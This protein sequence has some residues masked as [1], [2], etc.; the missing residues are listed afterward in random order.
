[1]KIVLIHPAFFDND[2]F[3][4]RYQDYV[5]WIR[6]GN[7]YVAPFEPPLG[8][9]YI[10]AYVKQQG[11]DVTLLDMQA[12]M[13]DSE[14][15]ASYFLEQRPDIVGITAMTPTL[16]EALRVAKTAHDL[17]PNVK[18]VLGGVHPTL[19]PVSVLKSPYVDFAVRGEG[20]YALCRLIDALSGKNV[21]FEDID[22]LCY[23][24][25]G[26]PHI[27]SKALPIPDLDALPGADYDSFP[28]ERYIEHNSLLR[29]IRGISMIVSRGCPYSC[30]FCAVHQTMSRLYRVK[31]APGVVDEVIDLRDRYGLEGVWFKD[32]IFNLKASWT[33][34]FCQTMIDRGVN[35]EWQALTR[36]NLLKDDE[37]A[38]MKKAGLRQIDLGIESG[39]P[40]SLKRLNKQIT[41]DQIRK[42]VKLAKKHVRV[43]GFFMIGIPGET[44][45]DVEQTF[46]FAKTLD[47]DRWSW[48]IYSPLPGST[49]Y[50]ELVAEGRVKS[51]R[52]NHQNIHFTRSYEGVTD[53]SPEKLEAYYSEINDYFTHRQ[54][55][56]ST[57]LAHG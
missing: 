22:G 52:L 12:L 21:R 34:D 11:Y 43:F 49:L 38:F 56:V 25:A 4:N 3:R 41:V 18:T 6:G 10:S 40:K 8:L 35:I 36:V 47:L 14:A 30:T 28:I 33:R 26:K 46:E 53:I 57:N 45:E 29:G 9:A 5:D 54:A 50:D 23:Q 51:V 48:S 1:M 42:K 13:M 16:P 37:L 55:S 39:S 17:L 44:E 32:S 19:D 24:S 7:L 20:E 2:E 15:L 27:V 31:S